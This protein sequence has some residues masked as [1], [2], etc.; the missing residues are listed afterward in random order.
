MCG[1]KAKETLK[2][3]ENFLLGNKSLKTVR[4]Y[5]IWFN[6][7]LA[8]VGD[9]PINELTVED[10]ILYKRHLLT[11]NLSSATIHCRI[12][13]VIQWLKFLKVVY[14]FSS[15]D[16]DDV[17]VLRPKIRNKIPSYLENWQI[18][19][20][21]ESCSDIE[22]EVIVRLLFTAGL[23]A[24]ELLDISMKTIT[25]DDKNTVWLKVRGKG[26]KERMIPLNDKTREVLERYIQY[27]EIKGEQLKNGRLFPFTY[28]TLW[29]RVKKIG[30]KAGIEVHPH[31]LRHTS[32]TA[33]L[34][35]GIDIRVIGE[36]LGHA[37]LNTT[38]RYAKVTPFALVD[39][40]KE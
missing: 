25:V 26:E 15:V 5:L 19:S 39:A 32:A 13:A 37:D 38:A 11:K 40:V 27:L 24:S 14:K 2:T 23:R 9:K 36:F 10:F 31:L 17:K 33:M 35:K 22:D 4:N 7:F 1:M 28:S 30:K 18:T 16:P 6:D 34:Q 3:Y 12:S 8:K 21:L 20:L 29:Y